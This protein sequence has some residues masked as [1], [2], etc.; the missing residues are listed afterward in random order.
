M[1]QGIWKQMGVYVKSVRWVLFGEGV[2]L[3]SVSYDTTISEILPTLGRWSVVI[4]RNVKFNRNTSQFIWQWE[5]G[6]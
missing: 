2:G 1:Q 4:Y 3:R 6:N 5:L